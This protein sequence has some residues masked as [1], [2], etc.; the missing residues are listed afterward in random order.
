MRTIIVESP[1]RFA[2]DLAVQL[3]GH[4]LNRQSSSAEHAAG[5]S[6]RAAHAG[7]GGGRGFYGRKTH[8]YER[9]E[10]SEPF[11][12]MT[13]VLRDRCEQLVADWHNDA[14]T[15]LPTMTVDLRT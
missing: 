14:V 1:D 11:R 15:G 8:K 4:D 2:R 7:S 9:D 3:A 12:L 6:R 10:Q 13:G 5:L